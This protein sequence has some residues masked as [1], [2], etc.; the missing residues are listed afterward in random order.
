VRYTTMITNTAQVPYLGITV[1]TDASAVFDDAVPNADQTAT[2]GILTLSGSGVSWSGDIPVGGSVTVS[3]SATVQNT[4]P[5][6]KLLAGITDD[7]V[8]N[9]DATATTG[10]LSF[11]SSTLAWTGNLAV[12]ASVTITYTITVN[13]PDTGD[14]VITNSVSSAEAGSTCPPGSTAAACR[15]TV[16]VLTPG[17]DIVQSTDVAT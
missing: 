17:L 5:G 3:G 7:A 12:G 16:A 13:A 11:A 8:Y 6:N 9:G 14:K 10:S 4:H 1:S 2:S 15:I